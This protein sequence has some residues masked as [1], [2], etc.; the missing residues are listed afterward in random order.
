MKRLYSLLSKSYETIYILKPDL[1]ENAILS[2]ITKYQQ[3]LYTNGCTNIFVYDRGRRHLSYPIRKYHDGIYIQVNYTATN[4][5]LDIL[6]KKF[7]I[8]ENIIRYL[9]VKNTQHTVSLKHPV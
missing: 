8:D 4:Q 3:L 7:R 2:I 9:T 6:E 5:V 1:D